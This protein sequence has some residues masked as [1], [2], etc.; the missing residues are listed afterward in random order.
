MQKLEAVNNVLR[1]VGLPPVPSLDTNG[2]SAAAHA[3]RFIDAASR[4]CQSR[5]WHFNTRRNVMLSRDP[6]TNKIAVPSGVFHIDTDG[7]SRHLDVTVVGGMLFDL[8]NNVDT[9]A[10]DLYVTYIANMDFADLPEAFA[11]YLV[12]ESA[13]QFNRYHKKDQALDQMLAQE[14]NLRWVRLRQADTG[15]ADV[16]LL[17]TGEMAQFRGRPRMRDRSVF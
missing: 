15:L 4:S 6:D 12:T 14:M 13:Y 10:Q 9:W 2:I 11:D 1:R 16:N 17:E 5:G 3:E 7:E 8:E